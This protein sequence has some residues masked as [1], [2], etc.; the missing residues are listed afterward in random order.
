MME[1]ARFFATQVED[2]TKTVIFCVALFMGAFVACGLFLR[3]FT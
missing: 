2:D 1:I 3:F